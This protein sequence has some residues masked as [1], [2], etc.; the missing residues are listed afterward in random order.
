MIIKTLEDVTRELRQIKDELDKFR[1]QNIDLNGRKI[2]NA[3]KSTKGND[4][5]TRQ[6][7]IDLLGVDIGPD[8]IEPG[9]LQVDFAVGTPEIGNDIAPRPVP[10]I[11][12]NEKAI[13][14]LCGARVTTAPSGGPVEIRWNHFS[15]FDDNTVDLFNSVLLTIPAGE[16]YAIITKFY[17]NRTIATQDYFTLDIISVNGATGLYTFLA[18]MVK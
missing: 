3:G 10:Y 6:E 9:I 14:I 15:K 8:K 5:I 18:L 1:S 12:A 7:V 17:P 4:Y 11:P 13:P 2:I 16:S